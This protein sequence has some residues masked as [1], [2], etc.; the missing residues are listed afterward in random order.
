MYVDRSVHSCLLADVL[1]EVD[2]LKHSMGALESSVIDKERELLRK[3]QAAREEE[4]Q[5][6]HK[7][8]S[9]K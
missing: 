5:K 2:V 8:E 6:L 4:W 9:E 1:D 7:V 3:V